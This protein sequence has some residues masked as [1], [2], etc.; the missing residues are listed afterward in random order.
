MSD[1]FTENEVPEPGV[2]YAGLT[3]FI[4]NEDPA[5]GAPYLEM[6]KYY[7]AECWRHYARFAVHALG[8]HGLTRLFRPPRAVNTGGRHEF[9]EQEHPTSGMPNLCGDYD[10]PALEIDEYSL[11]PLDTEG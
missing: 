10:L 11:P 2:P 5:D 4:E 7:G 6:P 1:D 9:I 3:E 8:A